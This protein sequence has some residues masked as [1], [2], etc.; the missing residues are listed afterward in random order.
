VY[1]VHS[2]AAW[3]QGEMHKGLVEKSHNNLADAM[4]NKEKINKGQ[5]GKSSG[6]PGISFSYL[7]LFGIKTNAN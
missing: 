6:R 3:K 5:S 2:V 4:K 7:F 1:K